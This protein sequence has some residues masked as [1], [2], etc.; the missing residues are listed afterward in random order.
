MTSNR[1][2]LSASTA[3][4][5]TVPQTARRGPNYISGPK[6]PYLDAMRA[7]LPAFKAGVF[8]RVLI[9]AFRQPDSPLGELLK[10]LKLPLY[11]M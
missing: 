8:I 11:S 5:V 10:N 9:L 1:A 2:I 3:P 7:A 4:R 6:S